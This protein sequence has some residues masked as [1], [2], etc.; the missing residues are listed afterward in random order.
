MLNPSVTKD[1]L[2]PFLLRLSLAAVFIYH[3][4]MKV[5]GEKNDW[6]AAWATQL[7]E[8]L[9]SIPP[10]LNERLKDYPGTPEQ[11]N[12]VHQ[13]LNSLYL[14]EGKKELPPVLAGTTAQFAVAWGEL[15]GGIAMLLGF[16]TRLAALGLIVIQVGAIATLTWFKGFSIEAGG[17][18]FNLVLVGVCL[19]LLLMGGGILSVDNLLFG[20]KPPQGR[21]TQA[22]QQTLMSAPTTTGL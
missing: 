10:D 4:A 5:T 20:R 16:L 9:G 12:D 1:A 3:G 17:Y 15:I 14:K 8:K 13:K 19:A 18:E 2:A 21:Q 11:K 6:G 22:Q 7:W